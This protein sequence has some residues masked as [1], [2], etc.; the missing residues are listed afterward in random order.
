MSDICSPESATASFTAVSAWAASGMS[1]ERVT[2][3]KPTP[4]TATLHRFSH[5]VGA[6]FSNTPSPPPGAERV[7]VRWG[8][9]ERLPTP[10]S[11]SHRSAM[12][13]SLSPLKGGEGGSGTLRSS[14]LLLFE[15][16]VRQRYVGVVLLD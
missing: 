9:P 7:G 3:E 2:W 13:P 10:T 8:I 16:D 6:S 15:V 4:L 11:P 14:S 1:A 12:G 5:I